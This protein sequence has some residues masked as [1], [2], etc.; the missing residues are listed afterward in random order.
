LDD[1]FDESARNLALN[2]L[3]AN[4]IGCAPYFPSIHLQPYYQEQ[5]GYKVGDFPHCEAVSN[6]SIA[7][8]FFPDLS[9]DEVHEVADALREILPQLPKRAKTLFR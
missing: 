3:R 6:R 7:L 9:E 5:F 1:D 2:R 4:G 8:P